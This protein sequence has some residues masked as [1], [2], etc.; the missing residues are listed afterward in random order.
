MGE[1]GGQNGKKGCKKAKN[2]KKKEELFCGQLFFYVLKFLGKS[3]F[4]L[5]LLHAGRSST[6]SVSIAS[7]CEMCV[8]VCVCM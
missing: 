5:L 6:S 4:Q 7:A 1:G 8:C 2:R 3:G